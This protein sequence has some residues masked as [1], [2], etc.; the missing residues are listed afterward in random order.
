MSRSLE[1]RIA[2]MEARERVIWLSIR[3]GET[4][5]QALAR[6]FPNGRPADTDLVFLSYL[7]D[8]EPDDPPPDPA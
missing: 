7:A 4:R 8:D 1:R 5:A 6:R 3:A 2:D